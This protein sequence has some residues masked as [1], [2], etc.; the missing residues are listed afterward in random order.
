MWHSLPFSER[1]NSQF[2]PECPFLAGRRYASE[3]L[4]LAGLGLFLPHS[5][6]RIRVD[7]GLGCGRFESARLP[8]DCQPDEIGGPSM[9]K[10]ALLLLT[11]L[12]VAGCSKSPGSRDTGYNGIPWGADVTTV[13]KALRVAPNL[14][15]AVSLFGSYDQGSA[16]KLNVLLEKGF[17][18]L[19]TNGSGT[20]LDKIDTLQ[21]I[22][23]LDQGKAGYS[24]FFNKRFGMNVRTIPAKDFRKYHD[25]LMKRYGVIDRKAE[26]RPNEYDSSYFI[27]WHD[28]DGKIILARE[29]YKTGSPEVTMSAQVIHMDKQ[30]FDTI[31]GQLS[32]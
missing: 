11:C 10:C 9:K 17:A 22:P 31:S 16:K 6:I 3:S 28:A 23:M 29:T 15:N 8:A 13:A 20:G 5:V 30:I 21:D 1:E 19:L 32:K 7:R 2:N 4:V 14:T 24:L 25:K 18:N 26:Y 27:M 12:I